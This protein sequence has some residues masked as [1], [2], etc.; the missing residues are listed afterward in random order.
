MTELYYRVA[1]LIRIIPDQHNYNTHGQGMS[2][3]GPRYGSRCN[4]DPKNSLGPGSISIPKLSKIPAINRK[5][6]GEQFGVL[7]LTEKNL[8]L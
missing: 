2:M 6:D 7:K 3:D 4:L 5:N 1:S 8:G